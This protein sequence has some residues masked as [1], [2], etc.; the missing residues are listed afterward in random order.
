MEFKASYNRSESTFNTNR[1]IGDFSNSGNVK[2]YDN[3]VNVSIKGNMFI[4]PIIA[5]TQGVRTLNGYTE[6]GSIQSALTYNGVNEHY[7]YYTI[8]VEK[9]VGDFTLKAVHYTD[10]VDEYTLKYTKGSDKV[11]LNVEGKRIISDYLNDTSI[12]AGLLIKF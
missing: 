4:N 3:F 1:S 6:T 12:Q 10:N 2:G 9:K 8:G 5:Y 7:N 11:S